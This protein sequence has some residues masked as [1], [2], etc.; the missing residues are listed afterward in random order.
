MSQA[1]KRCGAEHL[2]GRERIPPF[3]KIK[4][5][6]QDGGCAFVPFGDQ[7]VEVFIFGRTHGFQSEIV[8]DEQWHLGKGLEAPFVGADSLRVAQRAE[9]PGLGHEQDVVS[10]PGG[11]MTQCLREMGLARST[12]TGDQH[13]DLLVDKAAGR[14][15]MNDST[16]EIRQ[17]V[18]V[19][20][21]QCLL[22][23]E[24]RAAHAGVELSMIA[25]CDLV[26]DQQRQEVGI[27]ELAVDGFAVARFE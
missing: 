21:F 10:L 22:A 4:I 24:V 26:L 11:R 15:I 9:K 3:R 20:T 17:A 23:T 1:I 25:P 13:A 5:A 18:E 27:G 19:E 7:I 6:G 12:W 16:I 14:Q 8:N 2:V